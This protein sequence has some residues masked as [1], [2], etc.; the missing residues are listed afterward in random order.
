MSYVKWIR[1]HVGSQKI[2]LV[3]ATVILFDEN[4]RFLLQHRTDFDVCG[5]P[6]GVLELNEDIQPKGIL[7]AGDRLY[8]AGWRDYRGIEKKTG[9]PRDDNAFARDAILRVY[10]AEDGKEIQEIRLESEPVYNGIAAVPGKLVLALK[11]GQI[12][13]F[14]AEDQI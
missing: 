10:S 7:A 1:Q 9:L 5:L 13:C 4:G 14:G 11:S 2:F 8:L 12:V 6:G 3:Y